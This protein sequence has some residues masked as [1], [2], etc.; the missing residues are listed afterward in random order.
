MN[1]IV[2]RAFLGPL[3]LPAPSTPPADDAPPL[4]VLPPIPF[5]ALS[6]HAVD[7]AKRAHER[8]GYDVTGLV[9]TQRTR[10]SKCIVDDNR[11]AWLPAD[12][13]KKLLQWKRPKQDAAPEWAEEAPPDSDDEGERALALMANRLGIPFNS[14]IA[15]NTGWF[16]PGIADAFSTPGEAIEALFERIYTAPD[17]TVYRPGKPGRASGGAL[18]SVVITGTFECSGEIVAAPPAPEVTSAEALFERN[19]AKVKPPKPAPAPAPVET[20]QLSMF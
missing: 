18:P 5:E 20:P 3:L 1:L 8:A 16:V 7:V 13:A 12:E 2:Y 15:H 9:L 10:G 6:L 17:A 4:P 19:A 11:A 14:M